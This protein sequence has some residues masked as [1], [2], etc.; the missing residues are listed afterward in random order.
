MD[1]CALGFLITVD[2]RLLK[3]SGYHGE[4][5]ALWRRRRPGSPRSSAIGRQQA[6]NSKRHWQPLNYTFEIKVWTTNDH[7]VFDFFMT[8]TSAPLVFLSGTTCYS[9]VG[10]WPF[11]RDA[12]IFGTS[13]CFILTALKGSCRFYYSPCKQKKKKKIACEVF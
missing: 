10:P 1:T 12:H 13:I 7:C 11:R 9:R 2:T 4:E 5:P 8:K 3:H 6:A